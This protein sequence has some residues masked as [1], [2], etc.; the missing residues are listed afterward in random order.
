MDVTPRSAKTPGGTSTTTPRTRRPPRRRASNSKPAAVV[1][2]SWS[3]SAHLAIE[4]HEEQ[5]LPLLFPRSLGLQLSPSRYHCRWR[6]RNSNS[7]IIINIMKANMEAVVVVPQNGHLPRP[8]QQ[9]L[10][11]LSPVA[12]RGQWWRGCRTPKAA[13]SEG[14]VRC[15]ASVTVISAALLGGWRA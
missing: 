15:A 10:A 9:G 4:N 12:A 11:V 13:R 2:R 3:A 6:F 7:S 8:R 5:A 14:N 1:S